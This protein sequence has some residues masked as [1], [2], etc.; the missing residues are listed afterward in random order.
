MTDAVQLPAVGVLHDDLP[1]KDY[2]A[3]PGVGSSTLLTVGVSLALT[4]AEL[5]GRQDDAGSDD[6]TL[7]SLIHTA[8]L[9]PD[10]LESEYATGGTCQAVLGSG[11]RKGEPCGASGTLRGADGAWY[12][13]RHTNGVE[14]AA[15]DLPVVTPAQMAIAL[16]LRDAC[17]N[18]S[19][20]L[21]NPA[22]HELLTA[23]GRA[24]ASGFFNHGALRGK[25]RPDRLLDDGRHVSLKT[26][27]VGRAAASA[28]ARH[29]WNQ[30]FHVR[31]GWYRYGLIHCGY[32]P[33]EQIWLVPERGYPY[34]VAVWRMPLD[35]LQHGYDEALRRAD[36]LAHAIETDTWPGYHTDVQDLP[37][38]GWQERTIDHAYHN[39][40]QLDD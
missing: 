19:H 3:D 23:P 39:P 31:E 16:N 4:Q 2:L 20:P 1:M 17:T 38:L 21:F 35:I 30:E 26:V 37:L 36:R 28:Y 12:C 13:G 9:E 22:A 18:S 32:M 10:L 24:E 14:P 33:T 27:G 34:Q 7:G 11:K 6:A 5:K 8:L 15:E 25:V 40:E 29:A